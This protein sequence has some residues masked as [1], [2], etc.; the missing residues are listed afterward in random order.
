MLLFSYQEVISR[1]NF[2]LRVINGN[3]VNGRH[4]NSDEEYDADTDVEEL[5]TDGKVCTLMKGIIFYLF[6]R[7][8]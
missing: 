8:L 5:S 2:S 1:I 6:I 4:S 3:S 7:V